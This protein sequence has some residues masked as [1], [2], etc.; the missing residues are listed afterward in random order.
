MTLAKYWSPPSVVATPSMVNPASV[1]SARPISDPFSE[2]SIA[3]TI[4]TTN[5]FTHGFMA[6]EDVVPSLTT[7]NS[8][9]ETLNAPEVTI[10]QARMSKAGMAWVQR[11]YGLHRLG[12]YEEAIVCFDTAVESAPHLADAWQGKGICLGELDESDAAI[13][14]FERVILI[15]PNNYR[16][17]HNRGKALMRV[18][19]YEEAITCFKRVLQL[20][21]ENYK[22]W[23]NRGLCLDHLRH[24]EQAIHSFDQALSLKPDCYYGWSGRGNTL[25]R[26]HRY[27]E[28][29][30][31]FDRSIDLRSQNF[32][33][34]YGK[35][36]AY[37]ASR[38]ILQ[39]IGSLSQAMAYAPQAVWNLA[40]DDPAFSHIRHETAFQ[41]LFSP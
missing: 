32:P 8:S 2:D 3:T 15:D 13:A 1:L 28:A 40:K 21:P 18:D 23:Y 37:G 29:I 5:V 31:A 17:W 4:P 35:A 22:A 34:W 19:R 30:Y 11:G 6:V 12:N 24:L 20:K 27:D 36:A 38:Q 33:A 16:G 10:V 26:M 41:A 9:P 7:H 14:C 39:A 25:T